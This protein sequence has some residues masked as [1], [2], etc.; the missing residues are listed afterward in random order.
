MKLLLSGTACSP[1]PGSESF[2]MGAAS[3]RARRSGYRPAH[4]ALR[5]SGLHVR[6]AGTSNRMLRLLEMKKEE[7]CAV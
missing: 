7:A 3:E 6:P 1:V 4:Y 2:H 5:P